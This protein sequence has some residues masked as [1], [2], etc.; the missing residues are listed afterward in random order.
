M[1]FEV[2]D[3][4]ESKDDLRPKG[5]VIL[6]DDK[7]YIKHT[8]YAVIPSV[9]VCYFSAE[10]PRIEVMKFSAGGLAENYRKVC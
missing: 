9:F 8:H 1:K 2:G 4:Y 10:Y 5:Y 7:I 6:L 3:L